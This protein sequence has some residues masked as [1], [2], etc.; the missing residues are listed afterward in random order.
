MVLTLEEKAHIVALHKENVSNRDIACRVGTNEWS[1]RNVL[2]NFRLHGS[3]ARKAGSGRRKKTSPRDQR[4]IQGISLRNRFAHA[5][6]V[7]RTFKDQTGKIVSDRT[8]SRLLKGMGLNARRP[9]KKTLLTPRMRKQR[10]EWAK[11]YKN[12][13]QAEWARV[14]FSDES[15][16]NL[17]GPDGNAVVRRRKGERY[18]DNCILPTVK[19]SPYI[20]VWGAITR[21]GV[22]EIIMLRGSVNAME[23][24]KIIENGVVPTL[25]QLC[26]HCDSVIFQDDSAPAHRAKSVRFSFAYYLQTKIFIN[27][28]FFSLIL[29][30]KL[31][32]FFGDFLSSMAW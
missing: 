9:A 23:Y 31:Q 20:M 10:L 22:G 1:V 12:W 15:K 4:L 2:K 30:K 21:F 11:T 7:N 24:Q 18:S 17:F 19:H 16:F 3:I 26:Q 27:F 32:G 14:T 13:T 8:I 5:G 29:G 25:Q 6:D 28:S